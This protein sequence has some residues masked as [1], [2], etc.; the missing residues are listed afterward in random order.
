MKKIKTN[1]PN[2]S[3]IFISIVLVI[4]VSGSIP[5]LSSEYFLPTSFALPEFFVDSDFVGGLDNPTTMAF[6]PDGR[7]FV[8]EKEGDVRIIKNGSLLA[9]PFLSVDV[10][11]ENSSGLDG[12][13]FDPDFTTNGLVYVY[14]TTDDSPAHNR[15]SQFTADP[16]NPD[17][18]LAGSEVQIFNLDNLN[19]NPVHSGGAMHFGNDGKLYLTTGDAG[20][21]T[22]NAQ[23]LSTN[24]G[25]I[26][27]IN[28]DGTIPTDNPFFNTTKAKQEI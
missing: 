13:V 21:P 10:T 9:T 19:S 15:I 22:S 8:T 14:Y 16:A 1:S 23:D 11:S 7:L 28:S 17:V 25:K 26:I 18:A 4:L 6:A 3:F 27:R 24:L 2:F 20:S 12:I 5:G